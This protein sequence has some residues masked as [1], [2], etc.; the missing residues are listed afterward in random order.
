MFVC[1]CLNPPNPEQVDVQVKV[2]MYKEIKI[3]SVRQKFINVPSKNATL[4]S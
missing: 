1:S 2:P 4:S 3:P